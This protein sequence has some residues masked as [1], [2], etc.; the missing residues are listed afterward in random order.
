MVNTAFVEE[1]DEETGDHEM[2]A[3]YDPAVRDAILD[4]EGVAAE[5]LFPDADVLGTGRLASSPFG[6]GLGSGVGVDPSA[7]QAG[8]RAH[9]RWLADFCATNPARRIG[10]AVVPVTAGVDDAVAEIHAAAERGLRGVMIPTRWFDA[11][12]YLD[13]CYEPVWAACAEAGPRAAHPLR[14]RPGRLPAGPGLPVHLRRRGLVVGGPPV[15]GARAVG[16]VRAPPGPALL[17]RRER[18]LVG[19]RHRAAHGREVGGR[20]QHPQ[21]RRRLQARPADARPATTS[22]A[23]AS[24]PPRRPGADEIARRHEIGVGNLLWGNDL[25]HPEGTYPHTRK[26]IA[27]RFRDV[28]EDETARILGGNAAEVYRVD[29]P[30][31][32]DVV[33]RIGPSPADVHGEVRSRS[34]RDRSLQ[35]PIREEIRCVS[36]DGERG[37]QDAGTA[38]QGRRRHRRRRRHRPGA[39]RAVRR[40]GHAPRGGRRRGGRRSTRPWREL[41]RRRRRRRRRAHRRDVARV[42]RGAGRRRLRRPRRGPRAVQQRRRRPARRPGVGHRRPT[43]GRGPSASTCSASPT[44][45]RRSCPACW[46]RRGGRRGQH[47]VARRA[48]SPRCPR[49]RC[50]PPPSARSPA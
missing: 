34:P 5:V 35:R 47:V 49:P 11:P 10:V 50:T 24:S 19:A 9:N 15:L 1:W 32:A 16:R 40:R 8:A 21:V 18:R 13:P 26:W 27:E 44:A 25:P 22:T 14:R 36:C 17:D 43:T 6:S 3:G 7:V 46:P 48:R 31:L 2:K 38:G 42:G 23:T 33:D 29:V 4:Q 39:G 30:A 12:A 37:G 41:A 28:P 45:S 20:P